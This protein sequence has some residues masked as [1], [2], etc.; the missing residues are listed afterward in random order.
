MQLVSV[1]VPLR[2]NRP[3]PSPEEDEGAVELPLT[4]QLVSV[5]VPPSLYRPPPLSAVLPPVIVSPE[6]DAV[7]APST[8]NTRL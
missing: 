3:P 4:V 5:A 6:I 7:T 1:T 2:L 8:W